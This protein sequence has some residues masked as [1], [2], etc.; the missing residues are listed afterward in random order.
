MDEALTTAALRDVLRAGQRVWFADGT[1]SPL[2][3]GR[4]LST[5]GREIG[6]LD[7][8]LGWCHTR[9]IRACVDLSAFASVTSIMGGYGL[10]GAIE[11][12]TVA[13]VPARLSTLPALMSGPLAPD[14]VVVAVAPG[15]EGYRL[16]TEVT[17]V[18]AA[19]DRGAT[20]IGVVRESAPG[21]SAEPPLPPSA[22]VAVGSSRAQSVEHSAPELSPEVRK[23][24]ENV[25]ALIPEG[26]R[27]QHAPGQLGDAVLGALRAPVRID[28]G[29][30]TDA[31][32]D[33]EARGLLIGQPL[34][35]YAV[36]TRRLYSWLAA[37]P[38]LRRLE[39]THDPSRLACSDTPLF[40]VNTAIEIDAV[41]QVNVERTRTAPVGGVGGQPDFAAAAAACSGGLSIVALTSHG[42]AGSS[43]VEHL[44]APT[45]T[46]RHDVDVVVTEHGVADLRGLSDA[47]RRQALARL[48]GVQPRTAA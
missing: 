40:A 16:T 8:V 21:C 39:H 1:G 35:T 24:G 31:V 2:E 33:L 9:D 30:V 5:V 37:R 41:G 11:E 13:Y 42:P 23:V 44:S 18:P 48:W 38:C 29:M 7:L 32:V 47:G 20:V 4:A 12:G 14:A 17:W 22:V 46:P 15:P 34:A 27:V 45:T 6:G 25:A 28:S 3:L 36:G 19:I 26:A 43:L 10:R